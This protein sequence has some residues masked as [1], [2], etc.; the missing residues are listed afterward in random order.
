MLN[1]DERLLWFSEK[2]NKPKHTLGLTY[3]TMKAHRFIPSLCFYGEWTLCNPSDELLKSNTAPFS[4]SDQL[5]CSVSR[6]GTDWRRRSASRSSTKIRLVREREDGA[7]RSNQK[8]ADTVAE[9]RMRGHSGRDCNFPYLVW[10]SCREFKAMQCV[11]FL[12]FCYDGLLLL[13]YCFHSTLL[14]WTNIV[15]E[16][17]KKTKANKKREYF[18]TED[19]KPALGWDQNA[20]DNVDN[21]FK[22]QKME[23]E[24]GY[25]HQV[26]LEIHG[27]LPLTS[28]TMSY[29]CF[30]V[31]ILQCNKQL[32]CRRW[33]YTYCTGFHGYACKQAF[34]FF[35]KYVSLFNTKEWDCTKRATRRD[36]PFILKGLNNLWMGDRV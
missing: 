30:V 33:A 23:N 21:V 5:L 11:W 27:A 6:D 13:F 22:L 29:C 35:H 10:T 31:W 20:V 19:W 7:R 16:I 12:F 24:Q 2:G 15:V 1:K 9:V 34:M 36:G 4:F 18:S 25:S 32:C 26:L 17:L 28:A 8:W 3:C 14:R